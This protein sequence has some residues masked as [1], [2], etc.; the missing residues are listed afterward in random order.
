MATLVLTAAGTAIGGPIGGA[1]GAIVGQQIDGR[2]FAPKPRQGP[3]LG[4][5][6]VQ[7][8]SYGSQIP[9]LF[10]TMR[11]AGT[12]IWATDL[13]EERSKSGGGKGQPKIVDYSYS[14]NFA[15]A[16]SGRP[17]LTVRRIWADGK[18]LRGAAGDFKTSTGYRLHL[19]GEDQSV[20]PL[21]A[22]VEG[23]GETP[24]YRGVAYAVFEDFQLA[25]YGNRIP[26]LTFEVEADPGGTDVGSVAAALGEGVGT[27]GEW[28]ALAGYAAGGDSVRAAIAALAELE[29]LS[30]IDDGEGLVLAAGAGTPVL[31]GEAEPGAAEPGAGGRSEWLRR[32][33]DSVPAESTLAYY[34][35]ARDYQTGLQRASRPGQVLASDRSAVAAALDAATAK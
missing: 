35:P 33:G 30:L 21:I 32:S 24:A 20:D 1:I 7:T 25:D 2:L 34:D 29:P 5:L 11:V 19:G 6:A 3:R 26:S 22:A 17:I 15:V 9:K 12:V 18:L 10:G 16:L 28:A 4:E 13:R 14:A 31:I 8:S 23:A 27:A